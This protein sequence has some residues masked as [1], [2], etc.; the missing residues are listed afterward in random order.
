MG[1]LYCF[2]S[3]EMNMQSKTSRWLI[4]FAACAVMVGCGVSEKPEA[5]GP[6]AQSEPAAVAEHRPVTE[7]A[8]PR[9]GTETTAQPLAAESKSH[10]GWYM[11]RAGQGL[12]QSCGQSKQL[13][14]SGSAELRDKAREFGLDENTPVYVRLSGVRS[15]GGT[16]LVVSQVEQFGSTTPVRNCGLTGVVMAAPA[17]N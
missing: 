8:A 17:E 13:R 5:N 14:V 3:K 10:A 1:S 16:E 4:G 9:T 12:F 6:E 15:A 11:E 2:Q 7:S